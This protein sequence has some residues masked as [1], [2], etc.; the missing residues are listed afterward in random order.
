MAKVYSYRYIYT[1]IFHNGW[2]SQYMGK[3]VCVLEIY[4]HEPSLLGE[5]IYMYNT[6]E[7][8]EIYATMYVA[9]LRSSNIKKKKRTPMNL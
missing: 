9:T 1:E 2:Q 6:F 7:K 8:I 4:K 5:S 3:S